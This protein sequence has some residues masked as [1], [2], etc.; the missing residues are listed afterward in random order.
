[1]AQ[2]PVTVPGDRPKE[3][4]HEI[5][6]INENLLLGTYHVLD[7][8]HGAVRTADRES[9]GP[10]GQL[11]P[12]GSE[13]QGAQ[14]LGRPGVLLEA[15]GSHRAISTSPGAQNPGESRARLP[16]AWGGAQCCPHFEGAVGAPWGRE[17]PKKTPLSDSKPRARHQGKTTCQLSGTL[18]SVTSWLPQT[19]LPGSAGQARGVP[20]G[21]PR[22]P[23]PGQIPAF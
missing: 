3:G 22:F 19:G 16:A 21:E 9:R 12:V 10:Q 17:P 13:T 20:R 11:G 5:M 1:M 15:Q 14:G 2:S 18:S 4:A 7:P 23:H 6:V 8:G